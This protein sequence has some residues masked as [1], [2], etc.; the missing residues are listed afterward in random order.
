MIATKRQYGKE[1]VPGT[2]GYKK[3]RLA[4]HFVLTWSPNEQV[5]PDV[6]LEIAREFCEECL[7]DYEAVYAAHTD[8]AHM[9]AH[10]IFN[11]VNYRD[12]R[13][14]QY[15][16]NDWEKNLQ[17]LLDRLC[18]KHGLR[19]LQE[20]IGKTPA[21]CGEE[22]RNHIRHP[23]RMTG[24]YDRQGTYGKREK[25]ENYS[26]YDYL[27]ETLDMLVMECENLTEL[28]QWL[29][30][31]GYTVKYGTS[32]SWGRTMAIKNPEMKRFCRTQ[33]LG[34]DYTPDMLEKRMKAMHSPLPERQPEDTGEHW[35][36]TTTRIFR[37]RIYRIDNPY[38]RR[39][40]ARLY[41]LGV[42]PAKG[43]RLSYQERKERLK[44][45]RIL[46]Y[47]LELIAEGNYQKP[48]DFDGGIKKTEQE[49]ETLK[50]QE[51]LLK[52]EKRPY[53]KMME[54]YEQEEELAGDAL[55][56]EEGDKE[57]EKGA[58][59]YRELKR[60]TDKYPA[61]MEELK[62]YLE[63][64]SLQLSEI[65]QIKREKKKELEA[66]QELKENYRH[67]IENYEPADEEMLEKLKEH[68]AEEE[69]TRERMKKR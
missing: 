41:R 20:D 64:Q 47:Q 1:P 19:T 18:K 3:D 29:K 31:E 51:K 34:S 14:Y 21:E 33:T 40:Y 68:G 17:P 37:C 16:K 15:H 38:L 59:Q 6:A 27:R 43:K 12:G 67:V 36:F 60:Q 45:L 62:L 63:R 61:T 46:E 49:I 42:I 24:S 13:K 2:K 54:L 8:T 30:E 28:E 23:D 7:P 44:R 53:E 66:L 25:K 26:R 52:E 4:Y 56:Y 32:E 39:Q 9:H 50:Q 58:A 11:S 65:G 57:F 5:T 69:K 10:I 48:Q 55:L 35:I 22:R